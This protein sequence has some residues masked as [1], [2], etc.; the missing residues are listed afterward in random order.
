MVVQYTAGDFSPKDA[1]RPRVVFC[2]VIRESHLL[3][4]SIGRRA[5]RLGG[6]L[7][8]FMLSFCFVLQDLLLRVGTPPSLWFARISS[9]DLLLDLLF[10]AFVLV[11]SRSVVEVCS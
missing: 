6:A 8:R 2:G 3:S 10:I 4:V 9:L 5:P 7:W 11:G 1:S